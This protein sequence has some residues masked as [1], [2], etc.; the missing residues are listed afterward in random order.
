MRDDRLASNAPRILSLR[1]SHTIVRIQDTF[2]VRV[3]TLE[4]AL[5]GMLGAFVV[6]V[7]VAALGVEDGLVSAHF[8]WFCELAIYRGG[9]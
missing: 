6:V 8:C 1:R 3:R 4:G 9:T 7:C 5:F 2:L